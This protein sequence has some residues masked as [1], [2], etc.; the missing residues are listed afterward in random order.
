[1]RGRLFLPILKK[2]SLHL[3][4]LNGIKS[5]FQLFAPRLGKKVIFLKVMISCY[6]FPP[7]EEEN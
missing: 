7:R 5:H 4:P 3:P 1:M 6:L 2:Q